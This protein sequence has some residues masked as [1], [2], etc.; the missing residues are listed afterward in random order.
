MNFPNLKDQRGIHLDQVQVTGMLMSCVIG[1]FPNERQRKQPV[2][3]DLCLYLDTAKAA[4]STLIHD[5]LDYSHA[6][7]E[8]AF[9]LE[10]CEFLLIESAVEVISQYFMTTYQPDHDLPNVVAVAVRI[11]KPTALSNG[12][13]PAI[14]IVRKRTEQKTSPIMLIHNSEHGLL[15]LAKIDSGSTLNALKIGLPFG[16][17]LTIGKFSM[18]GVPLKTRTT[19]SI[20]PGEN[21]ENSQRTPQLLLLSK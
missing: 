6:V 1:I 19:V 15:A 18:N 14:Q 4:K 20:G 5:T 11:S 7:K 2:T 3:I 9:I 17:A 12:I 13:V 8:V 10:Q 21:L 16:T